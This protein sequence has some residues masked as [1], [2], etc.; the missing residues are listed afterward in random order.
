[1]RIILDDGRIAEVI[2][3]KQDNLYEYYIGDVRIGVLDTNVMEDNIL[4]L[5]NTLDNEIASQI[6]DTIN[7]LSREDIEF[8]SEITRE[9][10]T[11]M[12]ELGDRDLH[13]RDIRRI[14]IDEDWGK[15]PEEEKEEAKDDER[16]DEEEINKKD[17]AV[18]T[19]DVSIKQTIELSERANDM[20]DIRKWLG[21]RIPGD[22]KELGVIESDDMKMMRDA[23]GKR[24]KNN[25]TRYSLVIINNRGEVEPLSKYIPELEQ[26]DSSGNNP[27]EGKYQVRDD[28]TVKY[29]SVLSEYSIGDRVI[30][31]DNNEYGRIEVN[32]G[33]EARDSTETMG[34]QVRDSNT[35]FVPDTTTRSVIGEYE[36]NGEDT[37]EENLEEVKRHPNPD[38]RRMYERDIDG[39]LSTKSHIHIEDKIYLTDGTEMTFDELARRWGFYR[40]DGTPDGEYAKEKYAEKQNENLEK[41]PQE[42]VEELDEEFEDPRIQN[43]RGQ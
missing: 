20:H 10:D 17:E 26:K 33:E 2:V 36:Q 5:E 29:D 3:R 35:T 37:V 40:E 4:I 19:R 12:R 8:E 14:E 43:Q 25:T 41:E 18:T 39:D 9:I 1:M 23:E 28:G 13:V 24:M 21:G 7:R 42:I 31:I 11:Y 27:R 34:V 32:I 22:A 15:Q 38:D 16:D 6:K 30:Q